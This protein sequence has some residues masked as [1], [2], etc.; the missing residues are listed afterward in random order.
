MM[1]QREIYWEGVLSEHNMLDYTL[2]S[3]KDFSLE[4]SDHKYP[5]CEST[6]QVSVIPFEQQTFRIL[7]KCD[8][9]IYIFEG[10]QK[11]IQ[12]VIRDIY[13]PTCSND[14]VFTY[15]PATIPVSTTVKTA[16]PALAYLNVH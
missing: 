5:K 12:D 1:K 2:C 16:K 14:S 15:Q 8:Q 7:L 10:T 11:S 9:E 6:C 13:C 3:Q 4:R